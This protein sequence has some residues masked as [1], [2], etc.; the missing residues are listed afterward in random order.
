MPIYVNGIIRLSISIGLFKCEVIIIYFASRMKRVVSG[1]AH[2]L[3][4]ILWSFLFLFEIMADCADQW[5]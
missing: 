1:L 4:D 2:F 3:F 5:S